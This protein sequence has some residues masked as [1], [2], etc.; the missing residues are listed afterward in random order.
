MHELK[1]DVQ[2]AITYDAV[3]ALAL[4]INTTLDDSTNVSGIRYGNKVFMD[5][6]K[7]SLTKIAF[8]GA[9][10]YVNFDSRSGYINRIVDI[11]HING[12][13][14][15]NLVGFFNGSGISISSHDTQIFIITTT[16]YRTETIHPSVAT[17][18]LL[19]I[20]L[21][22]TATLILHIVSTINDNT[23]QLRPQVQYLIISSS[24]DAIFGQLLP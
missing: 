1:P 12:S 6:I 13:M 22:T 3:W 23:L 19:I 18:F 11:L 20:L 17:S 9:S 24:L 7:Q 5:K 14:D 4:A 8:D 15:D 2:A 16:L 21:Q 10:G